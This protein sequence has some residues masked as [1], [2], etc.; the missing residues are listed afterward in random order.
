MRIWV[1]ADACPV[2]VK[3]M[4][5][6]AAERV[7]VELVLV[8][9]RL[10]KVPPS[11]HIRSLRVPAGFDVADRY[12]ADASEAGDLVVTADIPLAAAVVKKGGLALN[13]RGEL[14][15][16]ENI[17]E[18]LSRRDLLDELRGLGLA[19]GGPPPFGHADKRAFA[20]KLD[21]VLTRALRGDRV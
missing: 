15:T 14:Y 7:G 13:P 10:L 3:E 11:P 8:A 19:A 17:G 20:A 16:A 18:H 21:T 6:R 2:V 9:N 5:Y 1:D 4:L 12:I